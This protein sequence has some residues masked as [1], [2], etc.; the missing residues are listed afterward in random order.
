MPIR[1]VRAAL[2]LAPA[3]LLAACA[4]LGVEQNEAAREARLLSEN[5]SGKVAGPPQSCIPIEQAR[6]PI[7]VSDRILLYRVGRTLTYRNDLASPCEG[8]AYDN[9]V[10]VA[11]PFGSQ[12]CEGDL[13]RL[14]NRYGGTG[15]AACSYGKFTPFRTPGA[16]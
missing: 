12:L 6:Q 14:V 4:P 10:I 11:E 3:L 2:I 16:G 1:S 9:D 8:L 15:A 13:I 5:L 7:R